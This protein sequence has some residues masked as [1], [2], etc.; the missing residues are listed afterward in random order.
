MSTGPESEFSPTVVTT[1]S[2]HPWRPRTLLSAGTDGSLHVWDWVDKTLNS[3]WVGKALQIGSSARIQ[4]WHADHMTLG[5]NYC[6]FSAKSC[7]ISYSMTC[8]ILSYTI[9]SIHYF[10]KWILNF[11]I[12]ILNIS[13]F[14]TWGGREK[15][16]FKIQEQWNHNYLYLKL[17]T[18]YLWVKLVLTDVVLDLME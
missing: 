15:C 2:W 8:N 14:F 17:S 13:I 6:F 12:Q 4:V 5:D 7:Y 3:C 9:G 16:V 10:Y 18:V 11:N 1:H